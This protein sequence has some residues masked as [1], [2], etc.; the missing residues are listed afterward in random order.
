MQQAGAKA[1]SVPRDCPAG[2]PEA[3]QDFDH[4]HGFWS[5]QVVPRK[6]D[7]GTKEGASPSPFF[8]S[9]LFFFLAFSFMKFEIPRFPLLFFQASLGSGSVCQANRKAFGRASGVVPSTSMMQYTKRVVDSWMFEAGKRSQAVW[10][11][12]NT[13]NDLTFGCFGS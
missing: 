9:N 8:F 4:F 3:Q 6:A 10:V 1:L 7:E 11:W 12:A 13:K 2:F 5:R